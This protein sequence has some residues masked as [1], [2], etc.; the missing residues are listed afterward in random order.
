MKT[1]RLILLAIQAAVK[2]GLKIIE[3][4]ES[5]HYNTVYKEDKSPLTA[6]D[7]KS[8]K[9]IQQHLLVSGLP[10]LSEEESDIPFSQRKHWEYFWLV[11]PLD[12]TREFLKKNDEFT[13][14]IALINKNS[15][16]AGIIYSP[17]NEILY[18]SVPGQGV[19]KTG[20]APAYVHRADSLLSLQNKSDKLPYAV[21]GD[22]ITVITSRSFHS[23]DTEKYILTLKKRYRKIVLISAGSA[24]KF[25]LIAE[26]KADIYPRL[27]PTME[28]DVAAGHALLKESGF[29][30]VDAVTGDSLVYNKPDMINPWFIAKNSRV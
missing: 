6:A 28:W 14:N 23:D 27:A 13:V 9:T 21:P 12:G 19:F 26:G 30:V 15:P 7:I 16:L 4:Y 5:N 20:S 22:T 18:Y 17:V 3:V 1:D 24:M 2:A 29:P 11:D 10:L 25:G 8:H